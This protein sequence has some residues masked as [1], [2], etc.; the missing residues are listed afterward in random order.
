MAALQR[1][2]ARR[3]APY[4]LLSDNGTNF[5][6]AS[7]ELRAA[8]TEI[9]SDKTIDAI[10]HSVF[11]HIT[12]K[13]SPPGAPHFVGLWEA[14]I[15]S[16]K[17][18]L[19]KNVGTQP[20]TFEQVTTLLTVAESILNSRPLKRLHSLPADG[21]PVLTP[22]HFLVGRPQL[23]PAP[24]STGQQLHIATPHRW[25]LLNRLK[26]ELWL[27]WQSSYLKS[28]Q[29]RSKWKRE[30]LNLKQEHLVLLKD[31]SLGTPNW[32]LAVITQAFPGKDQLVRVVELRCKGKLYRRPGSCVCFTAK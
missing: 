24:R 1:F 28:L 4:T 27:K 29:S 6:G 10:S 11:H 5:V 9:L 16:M 8:I 19:K 18:V 21:N 23:S 15:K 30:A 32:P 17:T 26:K 20:L 12:W 3:G 7:R 13:F 31:T 25:R 14:G 2:S 22:G